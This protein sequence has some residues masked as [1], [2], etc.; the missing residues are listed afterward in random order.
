MLIT[1]KVEIQP[2][3]FQEWL[4][5][6]HI[7][8]SRWAYNLFLDINKQ[9]YE[10]G[11]HYMNAYEFNTWFNHEYLVANPNDLWVKELYAKSIKQAFIDAH[12]AM[13]RFFEKIS[14]FPRWRSHKRNSGYYY[15]VKNGPKQPIVCE[16]HRIKLPKIGWI[17]LKEFGYIPTDSKHPI[18][19]GSVKKKAGRYYLT[20]IVDQID[21]YQPK[22]VGPALGIDLGIKELA[23]LSNGTVYG[24]KNK[25]PHLKKLEKRLKRLQ[26]K[27]SRQYLALKSRRQV[28]G[29]HAT[30]LNLSKTRLKIQRL[31]RKTTNIRTDYQNKIIANVVR[32][33]PRWVAIENLNIMG[34]MKNRHLA[35]AISQQRFYAFR[36]QLTSKCQRLGI[37]VHLVHRFEPTSKQCH[38][39][40]FKNSHL[41]LDDRIYH[42]SHCD[43]SIDRD[44]NAALNIRDT[45]N[46]TSAY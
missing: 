17:R 9:R 35:R 39:C 4:L 32:T 13:K 1:Y 27:F 20:C 12:T 44:L 31:N 8:G 24:N 33:K 41:T 22:L 46:Y 29:N 28:E 15:F 23:I 7:S 5:D 34:M 26:R 38:Q 16:R 10:S 45:K 11:Y 19:Q 2:T 40:G 18:R 43:Y 25:G 42:C 3:A 30:D 21:V 6:R 14:G 37:P 36:L